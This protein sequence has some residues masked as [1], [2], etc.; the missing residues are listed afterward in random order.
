MKPGDRVQLKHPFQPEVKLL[1]RYQ[2]AKVI[3]IIPPGRATNNNPGEVIVHLYDIDLNTFYT[4][5][6][7]VSPLYSFTYDE[8]IPLET[9]ASL[10]LADG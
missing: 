8:V 3:G 10:D 2:Y 5:E 6:A 1:R 9:S 4:D 7:G